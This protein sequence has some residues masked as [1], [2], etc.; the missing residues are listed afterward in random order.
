MQIFSFVISGI[1]FPMSGPDIY[2]E[3]LNLDHTVTIIHANYNE[4]LRS[5]QSELIFPQMMVENIAWV[6]DERIATNC[7]D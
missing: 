7:N 5:C 2:Y 4:L 3:L 6:G 1:S